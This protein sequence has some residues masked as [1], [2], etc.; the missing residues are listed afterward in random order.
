VHIPSLL[1][2]FRI[3]IDVAQK[4]LLKKP[5]VPKIATVKMV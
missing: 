4:Q 3:K 2:A 5:Q 1:E